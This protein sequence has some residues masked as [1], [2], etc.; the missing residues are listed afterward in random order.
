[1]R[2]ISWIAHHP[3]LAI[4]QNAR[5]DQRRPTRQGGFK[6]RIDAAVSRQFGERHDLRRRER[7][8]PS[9]IGA[10]RRAGIHPDGLGGFMTVV[11]G[12]VI[13]GLARHKESRIEAPVRRALWRYPSRPRH[14]AAGRQTKPHC[15]QQVVEA[16]ARAQQ[17]SRRAAGF[18]ADAMDEQHAAFLHGLAQRAHI[19][20]S[21]VAASMLASSSRS[22]NWATLASKCADASR[23][24]SFKSTL[25]PGKTK[26][27]PSVRDAPCRLSISTSI[28]GAASRSRI[29]VEA[30]L[31]RRLSVP[32]FIKGVARTNW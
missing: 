28:P 26:T 11:T 17:Q 9:P 32:A 21:A 16:A 14:Y 30:A 2:F 12:H 24:P 25:P 31:G 3:R 7:H 22:C 8:A 13:R 4:V 19:E 10:E 15:R 18:G 6:Y 29:N 1:M 23:R 5:L 20:A 27:P